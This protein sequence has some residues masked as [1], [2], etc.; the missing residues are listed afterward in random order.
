LRPVS[1]DLSQRC[2]P[3]S[4]EVDLL[5]EHFEPWLHQS[6]QVDVG[7][8]PCFSSRPVEAA[9][10]LAS[11]DVDALDANGIARA[12]WAASRSG[13]PSVPRL[14]EQ[15]AILPADFLGGEVLA[16]PRVMF[17]GMLFA[18]QGN[19]LQVTTEMRVAINIGHSRPMW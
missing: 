4:D 14:L 9:E 12:A 18:A 6:R 19:F 1:I 10:V 5:A 11:I 8:E 3:E 15:L 2:L 16:G 17:V 13:G 7:S